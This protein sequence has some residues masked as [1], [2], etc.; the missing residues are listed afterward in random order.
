MLSVLLD[1]VDLEAQEDPE[2]QAE[3]NEEDLEDLDG[4]SKAVKNSSQHVPA[5]FL[6]HTCNKPTRT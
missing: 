2:A 6:H 5:V 3:D 1:P 4:D